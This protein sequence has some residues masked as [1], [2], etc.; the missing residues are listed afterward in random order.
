MPRI[1]GIGD[2]RNELRFEAIGISGDRVAGSS[3]GPFKQ[4][5]GVDCTD[6]IAK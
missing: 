1:E 6:L 5:L 3:D 4:C 2:T